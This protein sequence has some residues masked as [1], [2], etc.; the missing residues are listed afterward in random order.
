MLNWFSDF[1]FDGYNEKG[2]HHFPQGNTGM[3]SYG[4]LHFPSGND[5]NLES[6]KSQYLYPQI[7]EL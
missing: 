4:N 3:F 1:C 6:A 2:T 7:R 5:F